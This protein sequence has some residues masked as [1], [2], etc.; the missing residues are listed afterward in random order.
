MKMHLRNTVFIALFFIS[1]PLF[2]QAQAEPAVI[3]TIQTTPIGGLICSYQK[4]SEFNEEQF[5]IQII[6]K[7][8][9][10]IYKQESD[11]IK[12]NDKMNLTSLIK[13]L[14]EGLTIIEDNEK[15]K[16]F[17]R[18]VY[19][20]SKDNNYLDNQFLTFWNKD[21]NISTS[22]NKMHTNELVDWLNNIKL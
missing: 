14:K 5:Q 17:D 8:Q 9:K 10:Y 16:T 12:I 19:I 11:T 13:D 1:S 2:S 4:V 18:G 6:F 22:L 7:N 15:S 20:I 21:Y 3:E